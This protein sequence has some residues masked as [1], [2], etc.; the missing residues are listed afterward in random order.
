MTSDLPRC[1][2]CRV[3]VK[4]G[5]NLVFRPDGRVNHVACPEVVC[6]VCACTIVPG[7]PI[8]RDH[9]R[10]VHAK[11]WARQYHAAKW[12]VDVVTADGIPASDPLRAMVSAKLAAGILPRM[13]F[14]RVWTRLGTG[15]VCSACEGVI[16]L[17]EVEN[18]V[19]GPDGDALQFHRACYDVWQTEVAKPR[20]AI[21]GGS[22]GM[23]WTLL[24]DACVAS[25]ARYKKL[26][27]LTAE[28]Q[29]AATQVRTRSARTRTNGRTD[30]PSFRAQ[31]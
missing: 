14:D 13:R 5:Q 1:A 9:E 15:S 17:G 25:R 7:D 20:R 8:R 24:R 22:A 18:K 26:L 6:P 12:G 30:R 10:P 3:S 31:G 11:C 16:A 28:T 2:V 21:A 23:P 27:V 19:F 4:P 29:L